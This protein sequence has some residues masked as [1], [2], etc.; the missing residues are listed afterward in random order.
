[1]ASDK[2]VVG[3][4]CMFARCSHL[5]RASG[6]LCVVAETI[7]PEGGLGWRGT[8]PLLTWGGSCTQVL[9]TGGG[10]GTQ[11]LRF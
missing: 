6:R 9:L 7:F 2:H 11:V 10:S 5:L 3:A 4:L 1:M 8:D